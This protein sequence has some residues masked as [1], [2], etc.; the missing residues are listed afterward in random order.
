VAGGLT[1]PRAPAEISPGGNGLAVLA[2]AA[3]VL[4][5]NG[6]DVTEAFLSGARAALALAQTES[7]GF[8]LLIDGSPSC[9]SDTIYDGTFAGRRVVGAGVTAALLREAGIVVFSPTR[10]GDLAAAIGGGA[11]R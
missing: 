2:G 6:E 1:T 3:R 11:S 4:A 9:G 7:C 5:F 8:A 10:I